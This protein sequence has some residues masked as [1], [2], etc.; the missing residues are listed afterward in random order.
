CNSLVATCG[1][2][3]TS[4]LTSAIFKV[5]VLPERKILLGLGKVALKEMEPVVLSTCP[6]TAS[7]T[8]LEEY[9]SPSAIINVTSGKVRRFNLS[10]LRPSTLSALACALE[11]YKKSDSF[12]AK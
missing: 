5:P 6:L 3:K 12:I 9:S 8:P 4:F 1:I 11:K 2:C 7:T 10:Y